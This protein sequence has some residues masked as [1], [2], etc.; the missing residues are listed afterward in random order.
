MQAS[1]AR[2]VAEIHAAA[3]P[4]EFLPSLGVG[5]LCVFYQAALES[6]AAFGFVQEADGQVGGFVLGS[7]DTSQLFRR[8]I[9]RAALPLGWAALP[10]VLR[11]PALLARVAETFLYP[12][13]E[14]AAHA[15]AELVV[16]A[17]DSQLRGQGSGQILVWAL[18]EAFLAQGVHSYKVTVLQSNP[19]ANRFYQRLGF[20]PAGEFKLY[21]KLWNL[22][23]RSLR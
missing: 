7:A 3:L 21:G 17:V 22:Y 14:A 19:G 12:Q 20:Y 6:G 13:R 18:E 16:I 15:A 10:A 9:L 4:G 1:H 23:T 5:F 2:R 8:V 11:R